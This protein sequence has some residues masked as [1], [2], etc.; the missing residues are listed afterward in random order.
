MYLE[1]SLSNL[2]FPYGNLKHIADAYNE[3]ASKLT[4]YD[5]FFSIKIWLTYLLFAFA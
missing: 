4:M 1:I 2:G 3:F 5:F